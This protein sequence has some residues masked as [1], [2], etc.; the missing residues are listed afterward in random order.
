[1][2]G[3]KKKVMKSR[4]GTIIGKKKGTSRTGYGSEHDQNII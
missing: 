3:K 1:L 2:G 4:R